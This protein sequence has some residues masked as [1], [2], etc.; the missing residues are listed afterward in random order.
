MHSFSFFFEFAEEDV[1]CPGRAEGTFTKD[2]GLLVMEPDYYEGVAA[3]LLVHDELYRLS[4]D[5][6]SV[7][8]RPDTSDD[9]W[10]GFFVD[11]VRDAFEPFYSGTLPDSAFTYVVSIDDD[12][13]LPVEPNISYDFDAD[14]NGVIR[15]ELLQIFVI[16]DAPEDGFA[17]PSPT[18]SDYEIVPDVVTAGNPLLR[19]WASASTTER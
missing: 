7:S 16:N 3:K 9:P 10:N 11:M 14:G 2:R 17:M 8:I 12:A 19:D 4:A 5:D 13:E 18:T 1:D 15:T 6:G